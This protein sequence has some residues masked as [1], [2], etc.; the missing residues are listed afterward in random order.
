[1]ELYFC[2]TFAEIFTSLFVD[3]GF[4]STVTSLA[5]GGAIWLLL[6]LLQGIGLSTMAKRRDIKHRFLAFL[7]FA[8]IWYM[9]KLAGECRVFGRKMKRAGLYAMLAQIFATVF[10]GLIFTSEVYLYYQNPFPE[11]IETS[12]VPCFNL[13]GFG[14]K[15]ETFYLE[16]AFF[17]SLFELVYA[18]LM[19]ILL[20][21]LLRRYT[22]RQYRLLTIL[23]L[24]CT[25][26][27]FVS[28][29]CVRGNEP[30]DYEAY[31]RAQREAYYHRQ[32]RYYG[33]YNR[34]NYGNPYGQNGYG[35][36]YGQNSYGNPPKQPDEP[37]EE[38]GSKNAADGKPKE[39][40][41]NDPDG[42]FD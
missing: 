23:F 11:M 10:V 27:R 36:A 2:K 16:S 22:P 20:T 12:F 13:T 34:G 5:V 39:K 4:Q 37:F 19:M 41:P 31:L 3:N 7:P 18:I 28:V 21:A 15:V 35:N 26:V 40:D 17:L 25:P 14:A 38:F 30:V 9:G 8:N 24:F 29:F 6:F 1:M 33:N 42:F 32:Q